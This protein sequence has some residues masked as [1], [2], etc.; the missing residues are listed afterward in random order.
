VSGRTVIT[1]DA[2]GSGSAQQMWEALRHARVEQKPRTLAHLEDALFRHYL[3]MARSMA[4][5]YAPD[6]ADPDAHAQAAEVG[7]AQAILAW[8]RPSTDGFDRFAG[9]AITD[10]LR[11]HDRFTRPRDRPGATPAVPASAVVVADPAS[12]GRR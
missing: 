7:L 10:Q 12:G 2:G 9:A 4:R 5:S 1:R 8:R 6:A 3:P 11:R